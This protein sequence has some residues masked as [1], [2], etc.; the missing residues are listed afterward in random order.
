[1]SVINIILLVIYVLTF[2]PTIKCMQ[3]GLEDEKISNVK[4]GAMFLVMWALSPIWIWGFVFVAI[5]VF[6]PRCNKR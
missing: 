2:Y 4:F 5:R 1:M 3:I 6:F